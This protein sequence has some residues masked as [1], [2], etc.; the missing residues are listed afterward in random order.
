MLKKI[1]SSRPSSRRAAGRFAIVASLYNRR[2][3]DGMLKPAVAALRQ[4]GAAEVQV[5]RVPGAYEIPVVTAR[6][7]GGQGRAG[8]FDAILTLG[9]I[10][11]GA[12]THAQHI[13]EAVT[14]ALSQIQLQ[15]GVP[16][17]HEVL[18]LENE[19]QAKERCLSRDHN[20]GAEAAHTA[21]D[22]AA[23]MRDLG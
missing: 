3:V 22:M 18:L 6:L 1:Q 23:V 17:I 19:Q 7:A 16:V 20:R 12:T 2:Y 9:V 11:R 8:R 10:L 14:M 15:H 4:A 13:G 5:V 21:L